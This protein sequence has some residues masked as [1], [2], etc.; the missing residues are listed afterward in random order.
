MMLSGPLLLR[1]ASRTAA[2]PRLALAARRPL[3]RISCS[4]GFSVPFSRSL[5]AAFTTP[6]VLLTERCVARLN[7]LNARQV[8]SS[9]PERLL[10]VSVEPGGCSGFQYAFNLQD[11]ANLA[12]DDSVFEREGA[13]VVVDECS[14]ELLRGATVDFEDDMMRTAFVISENP[15]ADASCGCGSS[16]Q[17]K[18]I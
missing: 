7:M 18:E 10:R 6:A 2:T 13:K 17:A 14:L 3:Q 1:V 5:C 15:I 11:A 9:S 16:F 8:E 12:E 4:G